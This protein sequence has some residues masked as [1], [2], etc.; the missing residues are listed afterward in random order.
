M[1]IYHLYEAFEQMSLSRSYHCLNIW[2]H[3]K[4]SCQKTRNKRYGEH[5]KKKNVYL[6]KQCSIGNLTVFDRILLS[7]SLHSSGYLIK[8]VNP[9]QE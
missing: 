8:I 1:K 9:K 3:V 5:L 4:S 2:I 7:Q 6:I